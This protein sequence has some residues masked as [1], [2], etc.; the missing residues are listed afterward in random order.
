MILPV[1]YI[2]LMRPKLQFIPMHRD[3]M[4]LVGRITPKAKRRDNFEEHLIL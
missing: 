1:R 3:Q 4:E 2:S